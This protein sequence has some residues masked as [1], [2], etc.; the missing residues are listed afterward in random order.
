MFAF[1]SSALQ[2][3]EESGS[4]LVV[5]CPPFYIA[6]AFSFVL[7]IAAFVM[8]WIAAGRDLGQKGLLIL[9]ASETPFLLV[10]AGLATTGAVAVVD[11]QS[12]LLEVRSRVFGI[13]RRQSFPLSSV[14]RADVQSGRGSQRLVFQLKDGSIV[15]LGFFTNQAGHGQAASAINHFL[16]K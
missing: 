15:P 8:I 1:P 7:T 16:R 10:S 12:G 9:L 2:A 4:R 5:I 13:G 14:E 3:V 11:T 6:A